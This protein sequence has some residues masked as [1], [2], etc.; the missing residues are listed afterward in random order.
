LVKIKRAVGKQIVQKRRLDLTRI[1]M[2]EQGGTGKELSE[3]VDVFLLSRC[4]TMQDFNNYL[5]QI[6]E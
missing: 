5:Y 1:L 2:K 6:C 3:C 4:S